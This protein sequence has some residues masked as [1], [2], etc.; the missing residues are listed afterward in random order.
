MKCKY[1]FAGQMI[2]QVF[3]LFPYQKVNVLFLL[4]KVKFVSDLAPNGSGVLRLLKLVSNKIFSI[5][6]PETKIVD[7]LDL[8][9]YADFFFLINKNFSTIF[10]SKFKT[11]KQ[12]ST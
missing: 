11:L 6:R 7:L 8:A 5:C 4:Y 2:E 1:T 10:V 3:K 9:G 12:Q